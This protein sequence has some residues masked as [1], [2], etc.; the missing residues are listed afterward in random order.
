MRTLE[1]SEQMFNDI[2]INPNKVCD[3]Q[4]GRKVK[5]IPDVTSIRKERT[6]ASV[7]GKMT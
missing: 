3:I 6:E 4:V 2:V 5:K 7:S 1:T